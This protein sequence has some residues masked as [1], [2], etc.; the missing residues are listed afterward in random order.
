MRLVL[1]FAL[2]LAAGA[3]SKQIGDDCGNSADCSA[4][5]DRICDTSVPGNGYCTIAGCDLG[6]C[7]GEA[8][9]VRFFPTTFLPAQDGCL[10]RKAAGDPAPCGADSIC[11]TSTGQCAPTSVERRFCMKTCTLDSECRPGFVCAHTGDVAKGG[12]A[13]AEAV[14]RADGTFSNVSFCEIAQS[15]Q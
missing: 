2:A 1:V 10:T 12:T 14:P 15:K 6:T 8:A 4:N 11:L 13:G 9:C 7:P 3:C 5:G